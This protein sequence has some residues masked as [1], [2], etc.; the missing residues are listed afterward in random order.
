VNLR[1]CILGFLFSSRLLSVSSDAA[2]PANS[3]VGSKSCR[4]CHEGFY[5]KWATSHHGLAMQPFTES[6]ARAQLTPMTNQVVVGKHLYRADLAAT[7]A[8]VREEGPGGEKQFRIEH[9]LGGKNVFYFLALLEKGRLQTLPVAYDV[10]RKEWF[11]TSASA[12]RHFPNVT[13]ELVHWTE[14]PYTFNTACHSC[15]VSQLARNYDPV[16]ESYHTT[17][18]EPGINC[19]TCHGPSADH[20]RVCVAAGERKPEDLKIIRTKT[21]TPAQ[22]NDHCSVCHAKAM[23]L[24][25]SF[26]PGARLLDH[27][28]LVTLENPDYYPDGR[29][30]GENYTYTSWRL[31]P[32]LKSAQFEC[33]HCHTSSGRFR[34]KDDPNTACLPCHEQRVQSAAAHSHH[35]PDSVGSQCI[36]CHM[37]KTE[38]ARMVRSDHSMRPPTPAATMAFKSPNACNV[39]HTNKEAGWAD[40]L[41]REWHKDDFQAAI[42][43]RAGLVDAARKGEWSRLP[44]ILGY[45]ASADRNE[46][47][48]ASLVRLLNNCNQ[49]SKWPALRRAATDSSPLVRAAA[50]AE[51]QADLGEKAT[52][53]A[54]LKALKD[55]YRSVRLAAASTMAGYPRQQ[56]GQAEAEQLDRVLKEYRLMLECRPDDSLSKYNLGNFHHLRGDR[57]A[58][59]TAY[60]TSARLDPANILPLV[61]VSMLYAEAGQLEKAEEA[62]RRALKREPASAPAN[63]N[64]G[65]LV[66]ERGD[67]KDAQ[68]FLRVAL[69]TDP[70]MAPAAYNLAVL[71]G[72]DQPDEAIM[73]CRQAVKSRPA[74]PKYGFTLAYYLLQ[75]GAES[76]AV[77]ALEKV[78]AETPGHLDSVQM[79]GQLHERAGRDKEAATLYERT[80]TCVGLPVEVQAALRA[81]LE[82]LKK[83]LAR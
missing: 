55:D 12:M 76:E 38:F 1:A 29:D 64:L 48:A 28:G 2:T 49:A 58:A 62:L 59:I 57:G 46:I 4:D 43:R 32:C 41:V 70:A 40:I 78:L 42:L 20:V 39:C 31:S 17:W 53:E 56:L 27:F 6:F 33:L 72:G 80:L 8:V 5:Q 21:M 44:E 74:E 71:V 67:L 36:S 25:D 15:H 10:R 11:D 81:R 3:F 14:P 52:L 68:V 22:R 45:L 83:S 54:V 34:Q 35:P 50:L 23:I 73:L 9:V 66:A 79:L 47:F 26:P 16:T 24:S 19:E 51:L 61:N 7:P 63:F 18:K 13:N 77:S 60:E 37:P 82:R 75:K 30:L 65:L 69:K